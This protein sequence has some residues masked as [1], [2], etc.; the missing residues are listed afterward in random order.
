MA[1]LATMTGYEEFVNEVNAKF[2]SDLMD[3]VEMW[4]NQRDPSG[5]CQRLNSALLKQVTE[6]HLIIDTV[7]HTWEAEERYDRFFQHKATCE[8]NGLK[9]PLP[10]RCTTI[11]QV[12]AQFTQLQQQAAT[13]RSNPGLL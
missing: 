9:I 13:W 12:K 4:A 1:G 8:R 7:W 3:F 6:E 5:E 10:A 11:D 2:T